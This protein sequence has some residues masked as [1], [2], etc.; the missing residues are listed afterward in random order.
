MINNETYMAVYKGDGTST[1]FPIT[2]AY[3]GADT[4]TGV[5]E[6]AN[7]NLKTITSDFYVDNTNKTFNYPGYPP[8]QEMAG[9]TPAVL[10][11]GEKLYIIRNTALTQDVSLLNKTPFSTIS[12][13]GTAKADG[14]SAVSTAQKK[15]T[16]TISA[17]QD[18]ATT[19][20][21]T[22]KTNAVNTITSLV[23]ETQTNASAA[24]KSAQAAAKSATE[25]AQPQ[26]QADY[27]ETD[28]NAKSYI[29]NKP[30]VFLKTGG[31]I[32]GNTEIEVPTVG[33]LNIPLKVQVPN[34]NDGEGV[35]LNLGKEGSTY[36]RFSLG[37]E[38][39][40]SGAKTN[41]F[42][43]SSFN[44]A[45]Y[46]FDAVGNACFPGGLSTTDLSARKLN[47][48]S[49]G[50]TTTTLTATGETSV[51]TANDGNKSNTIASTEFVQNAVAG[52]VDSAPDALNTLKELA[53]A[54]GNDANFSTTITT[55]IGEKV[56]P[57]AYLF[58]SITMDGKWRDMA[59]IIARI[60]NAGGMAIVDNTFGAQNPSPID[61]GADFVVESLTKYVTGYLDGMSGLLAV[62]NDR[63]TE[64]DMIEMTEYFQHGGM[65]ATK[66]TRQRVKYGMETFDLRM[67]RIA[68]NARTVTRKLADMGFHAAYPGVGGVIWIHGVEKEIV[69]RFRYISGSDTFGLNYTTYTAQ[70]SH[71]YTCCLL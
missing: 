56:K 55:L 33:T 12:D 18:T 13:I 25:A 37:F 44:G 8:G 57:C 49:D 60:H 38:Y 46:T 64:M 68:Q 30:N 5:I 59:G 28:T 15:A 26:I 10:A 58:D 66:E 40:S 9:N 14:L 39:T 29:K 7:G 50:I 23:T 54:L 53:N 36:N 69:N 48:G 20:I 65:L 2:F 71:V 61:S 35:Y 67:A 42:S 32:T 19:A 34:L 21:T 41:A 70:A 4:V 22:E 51:P 27:A 6:D 43:I 31:K 45:H 24:E 16:D 3:A 1:S 52:I 47:I 63:I 62:H 17:A 11:S